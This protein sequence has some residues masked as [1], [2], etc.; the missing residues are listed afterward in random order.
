VTNLNRAK[1][2]ALNHLSHEIKTPLSILSATL[3]ILSKK[4]G[5]LTDTSWKRAM[6]R[7][8]RN[9]SRLLDIQDEVQDILQAR[10]SE[11]HT[12][13]SLLLDLCSD[14]L[15]SIAAQEFGEGHITDVIR[16]RIDEIFGPKDLTPQKLILSDFVK[17]RIEELKPQ[18]A[19]R[20]VQIS[21]RLTSSSSISLPGEVLQKVFDGLFKNAVENT[22]D[23]GKVTVIVARQGQGIELCVQDEG[24][25]ITEDLQKFVFEGFVSTQ[26][27]MQYS[28]KRPFDFNAGGKGADLLRIKLFSER[29]QFQINL[30]STRCHYIPR[31]TDVCPGD[32]ME[33]EHCRKAEDCRNSGGTVLRVFFPDIKNKTDQ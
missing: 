33:C 12:F 18:N 28:S 16:K 17:K 19:H 25:G 9:L 2:K 6:E 14:E 13:L 1:D 21:T 26:D 11:T 7:A 31:E 27:T 20:K 24:V 4:M 23:E 3:G 22:P 15:E 30:E 5:S 8:D 32:I 29:Y 10:Y